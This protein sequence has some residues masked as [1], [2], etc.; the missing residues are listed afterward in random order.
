[1]TTPTA[2]YLDTDVLVCGGGSAGMTAAIAAARTGAATTLVERYGFPGGISTQVLDTFYGFYL[3]GQADSGERPERVVGGIPW[4][5]ASAL[6]ASGAA[7][8][9]PNSYGAGTGVTYDPTALKVLW[10]RTALDAGVRLLYHAFVCG[11]L[12]GGD[13]L[14]GVR[15]ATKAGLLE[16][17]ARVVVDATGD[18]DVAAWAGAPFEKAGASGESQAMTT[19]F[20]MINVDVD[21]AKAVRQPE[22]QRLMA[23]AIEAGYDLPRREGSVHVTPLPGTMVT[24]MTRVAGLD[25]TDPEDLTRAEVEG[26]RQAMEYARFL[27]DRVPGYEDAVI[28]GVS[29]QIGV[30]ETRRIHGHYRL[31]REDVLEARDHPDGIARCGAPIEAHSAG[32]GDTRWEYLPAGRTYAIPYRCLVPRQIDNLL[33]AGRCLS[34]T[35]DAHASV[36]SMAQCMAMG[37]AAGTAAALALRTATKPHTLNTDHLRTRLEADGVIL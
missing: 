25:P 21:R 23:E 9:R 35:Y 29:N 10:E 34:A 27:T 7:I 16:I 2:P 15:V 19:T 36:R 5:I 13:R 3:P 8:E 24:N 18:G 37:Q 14:H 31:A 12:A 20:S 26:R 11:A 33:V 4:E 6:L 32:K 30:R 28:G 22:L 1:M 17:R